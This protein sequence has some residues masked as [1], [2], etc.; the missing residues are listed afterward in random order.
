MK[1]IVLITGGFDPL[2]S[3]HIAYI[4]AAKELGDSLIVGVNSDSWLRRKKGQ[5]FMPWEERATIIA[6]LHN[7]DRVI[8][9]DDS[10]N[11][12]KDAIRKVRAI[13]PMAQIIFANG[14]DRTKENI[15][16]MDLLEEMLHLEFVFGVGGENKM[17]SS[18]WILQEWK[19]PKTERS[20]G[21]YRVLHEDG[22]GLKVKE[23]TVNPRQ[24]L[25]MQRHQHRF[26]HWFVTEGTATVNTLDEEEKVVMKK[27]AMKNMQTYIGKD[28]WH[29]LVN[30]N[31]T[32]LKVIEIQFGEQCVE[33][34][35][36]RK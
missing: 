30:K 5:E 25:S 26:E 8:N 27:F 4:K 9:F 11:S 13:H 22:P 36:E 1:R 20:W 32:P 35:I 3:G 18:S 21:Y 23:L 24:S 28:E 2:H 31:D 16:E 14:G 29:Q 6:A 10:D 33:E 15:P 7:V 19:A 34:D 17:N 12:A